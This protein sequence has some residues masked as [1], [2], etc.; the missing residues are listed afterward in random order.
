[1][2]GFL[3]GMAFILIAVVAWFVYSLLYGG[4]IPQAHAD[5]CAP[6]DVCFSPNG[7]CDEKIFKYLDQQ[8]RARKNIDIRVN[9]YII[10]NHNFSER[11]EALSER[12]HDVKILYD[13]Q[14]EEGF[15]ASSCKIGTMPG[16]KSKRIELHGA[17]DHNKYIIVGNYLVI[18]GSA[19]LTKQAYEKNLENV[20]FIW[21]RDIV[22]KYVADF[23]SNWTRF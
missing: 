22:K 12:G 8:L 3:Y 4:L 23:D 11:L 21:D 5:I 7:K 10:S 15:L 16:V 9:A 1:M 6:I 2:R 19:N 18:T 17:I 13:R 14:C 20:V